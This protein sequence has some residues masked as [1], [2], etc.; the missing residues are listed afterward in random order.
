VK[1]KI[2]G[3]VVGLGIVTSI[4]EFGWPA[5]RQAVLHAN[6]GDWDSA[7][8]APFVT[9]PHEMVTRMLEVA[10]IKKGD[11]LYDLGSGDG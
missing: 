2:S 10:E 1:N 8:V 7:H 9:T 3:L 6:D 4:L 11:I 5:K